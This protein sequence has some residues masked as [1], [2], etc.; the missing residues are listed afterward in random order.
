MDYKLLSNDDNYQLLLHDK[1]HII[2]TSN[3]T[4]KLCL[5]IVSKL[6]LLLTLSK[7]SEPF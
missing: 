2:L 6:K 4:C 3:G 1:L 5:V 7:Y